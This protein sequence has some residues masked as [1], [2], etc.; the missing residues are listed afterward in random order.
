MAATPNGDGYWLVAADGGIFAFGDAGFYGSTGSIHLN[1][2]IV[3]M[4][5]T[6]DGRG[7]WLVAADGG[8]FAF[9]DA[10]FYGSTGNIHLPS[11]SSGMAATQRTGLLAGGRRRRDLRLRRRRVLRLARLDPQSRPIVAM[12]TTADGGGY[13][14]TNNNGAVTAFGDA[15]YWGSTPQVL[16]A[17]W[18]GITEAP[19]TALHRVLL[20]VGQLRLRHLQLPVSVG[21]GDLPPQPHTIGI[22]QVEEPGY[23]ESL[24]GPGGR[25][26]G[27]WP[28]P[29]HLPNYGTGPPS[30]DP[31]CAA[32]ASPGACDYGFS[33]AIQAFDDAEAAGV[34]TSV[35]WWLDVEDSSFDNRPDRHGRPGAGDDRRSPLRRASTAWASMRVPR[36]GP[37]SSGRTHPRSPTGRPTGASPPGLRARMSGPSIRGSRRDR[38]NW[39]NTAHLRSS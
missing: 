3:G 14:F 18:S 21:R 5:S 39:S 24:S 13:W 6:A 22:V 11:R 26:G 23:P 12:A 8:V 38:S 2:P 17:R 16:H 20:P 9:G 27:R 34:N 4:A 28:Q 7:Y 32:T 35:P 31:D 15:T 36:T 30:G 29:L 10:G 1:Q 37:R 19:V 33:A 25:L